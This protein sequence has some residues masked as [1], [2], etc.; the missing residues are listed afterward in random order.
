MPPA[1]RAEKTSYGPRRVP[2]CS[3]TAENVGIIPVRLRT[4]V[5]IGLVKLTRLFR[6]AL[7]TLGQHRDLVDRHRR[8]PDACRGGPI[9]S[10]RTNGAQLCDVERLLVG[11][12]EG[13]RDRPARRRNE[14]EVFPFRRQHVHA[15]SAGYVQATG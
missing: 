9:L 13:E 8:V 14:T 5:G 7:E 12:R 3:V 2:G 10:V 6:A 4:L 11:P 15:G 1:P